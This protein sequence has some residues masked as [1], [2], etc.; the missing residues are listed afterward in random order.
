MFELRDIRPEDKPLLQQFH[1]RLS[2]ETR[3]RRYHGV[4]GALTKGDLR[5][6]TEVDG[7]QHVALVAVSDDGTFGGVARV[8]ADGDD[9]ELAIVVAD[10][11]QGAGVGGLLLQALLKRAREE[12]HHRIIFEV[13][14]DNH[15]ALRCFQGLGARQVGIRS[16]VCRLVVDL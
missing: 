8:V 6:L 1:A 13:Q 11:V 9:S 10:D 15:R 3:Y 4:K 16:G 12:G 2:D 5:Y 14:A 7:H